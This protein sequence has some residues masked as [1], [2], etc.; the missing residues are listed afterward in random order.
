MVHCGAIP[1]SR[2]AQHVPVGDLDDLL[3]FHPLPLY[4]PCG[5]GPVAAKARQQHS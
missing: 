3:S 2:L 4:D 1:Y 5:F